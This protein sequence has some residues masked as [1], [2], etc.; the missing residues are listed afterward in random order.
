LNSLDPPL[1]KQESSPSASN[2]HR[3]LAIIFLIVIIGEIYLPI[4]TQEFVNWD[5]PKHIK[6]V[7]KPSWERAWRIATDWDLRYSNVA[8]YA[9]FHFLSLMA[10]Q[11]LV[12]SDIAPSPWIA[13]AMNV[14]HHLLNTLLFFV[15]LSAVGLSWRA[16]FMGALVFGIHPIQVGTVAWIAERK[17]LLATLLYLSALFLFIQRLPTDRRYSTLILL[18]FLAGLLSKPSVTTFP[19]VAAAWVFVIPD[20]RLRRRDVYVLLGLM[21][22]ISVWWGVYV[23]STEVSYPGIL[24][25]LQYRPL[26]AAG[27]IFFYLG[28]F[29]CPYRLVPIYPRWDVTSEAWVFACL[30]LLLFAAVAVLI[31]NR[32]R[33]DR[34]ILWGLMFFL[35]N[36]LPVS[37]L[38]SF[39]YMSHSFV[40]DHLLYLP[41][42]GLAVAVARGI[43]IIFER[44]ETRPRYRYIALAAG[45][46]VI[47]VWG[48]LAVRQTLLWRD[49]GALWEETLKVTTTSP[50][51]Y[52][53]FGTVYV[54]KGEWEKALHFFQKAVELAPGM[55]LA[56]LNMG[57][58]YHRMGHKDKV[59]EMFQIALALN[60]E[61]MNALALVATTLREDGKVTEA[62]GLLNEAIARHPD[63]TLMSELGTCY[64]DAGRQ[65][66]ALEVFDKAIRLQPLF[67]DPYTGKALILLTRGDTDN[68]IPLLK[69]SVALEP[70]PV[71][72][73]AL[74]TAYAS[75]GDAEQA[76]REFLQGYRLRPD[77][78]EIRQ[79][80]I[81]ALATLSDFES[82]DFFCSDCA[83]RGFPCSETDLKKIREK[84]APATSD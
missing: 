44:V 30:L 59:R 28:K 65:Q 29:L 19:V 37:G 53:N 32:N 27:A 12:R 16:A 84:F 56:Y 73:N 68:A 15:F 78:K 5:D 25:P 1:Q 71:A 43:E 42:V 20:G 64:R 39:G 34:L 31:Y 40:A 7:W 35:I 3:W 69:Q 23:T 82:A 17:N 33:I 21:M 63:P 48:V 45:Y 11:A 79:N 24:P 50:T 57:K 60:P 9:P 22:L 80:I 46:A 55:D 36:I 8:Y 52:C 13:K 66:D 62:I 54:E 76:L 75:K 6:V 72:L 26:L 81:T 47:T 70:T 10:D 77:M 4:T 38:V 67:P 18:L 2:S 49:P 58:I 14:L 41:M 74:G 61:N 83:R 51:V